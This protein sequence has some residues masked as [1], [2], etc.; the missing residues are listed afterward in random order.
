MARLW[1]PF[2]R[3]PHIAVFGISGSG[4]SWL[5]RY[6]ILPLR[7][8]TR[9]VLIDVKDDRDSTWE[10]YGHPV[11]ELPAAFFKTGNGDSERPC[12][13]RV[14]VDRSNAQAQLRRIFDQIRNEGHC[15]L[16]I[17]ESRSI[18]EREQMGLGSVV[19]NLILEGRGLG[20]TVIMGAQSSAWAVASLKDQAACLLIGQ[21][22]D[23]DQALKLA[24]IAGYGRNL[25][26]VIE[27]IPA[28][29]WL[30]RDKWEGASILALTDAPSGPSNV[31]E[32]RPA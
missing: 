5:I 23:Q 17:D 27:Q 13:W 1:D 7:A 22:S 28:R 12:T 11:T 10:G 3:N 31:R 8:Y 18:T 15:L 26:P 24:K 21:T 4:K 19:E 29:Q 6:G 30:Y 2:E 9:T 20:I 16:V 14:I 32:I 25:S